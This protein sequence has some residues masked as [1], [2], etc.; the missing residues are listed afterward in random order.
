MAV[1]QLPVAIAAGFADGALVRADAFRAARAIDDRSVRAHRNLGNL[2]IDTGA[3]TEGFA[4]LER[5]MAL[6]PDEP[7]AEGPEG[8]ARWLPFFTH[9]VP[10]VLIFGL[11]IGAMT[12]GWATPTEAGG[13]LG[14]RPRLPDPVTRIALDVLVGEVI[15]DRVPIGSVLRFRSGRRGRRGR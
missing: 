13:T 2:L 15:P 6:A 1:Y 12:G 7:V 4:H 11:V 10:L 3:R 5:A 8:L 9:V 14:V